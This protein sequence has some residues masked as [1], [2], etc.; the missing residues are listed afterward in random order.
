MEPYASSDA[1]RRQRIPLP[2]R[3]APRRRRAAH[4]DLVAERMAPVVPATWCPFLEV[5]GAC[6]QSCDRCDALPPPRDLVAEWLVTV[7]CEVCGQRH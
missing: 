2:Y 7:P 5:G 1:F 3:D 4:P 6:P